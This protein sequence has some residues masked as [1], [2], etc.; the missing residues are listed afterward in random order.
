MKTGCRLLVVSMLMLLGSGAQALTAAPADISQPLG[1]TRDIGFRTS[2]GTWMS[3]D[4]SPDGRWIVFD[5]LGHIYRMPTSGGEAV[6]L[7]QASGVALNYHPRVSPDGRTIA[8]ISDRGGQENL[9]IM[10]AEGANPR[11]VALDSNARFAE[12]A[13]SPDGRSLLVTKRAKTSAGFYRTADSIWR[14]PVTGGSGA[15]LVA[16]GA[17]GGGAPA[18]TG[19][20]NGSGRAQWPS[21]TRDG[22]HVYFQTADFS[23]GGERRLMRLD[24]SGGHIVPVTESKAKA[25]QCCGVIAHPTHLVDVAPEVSPDG[26]YLAFARK[27]PEGKTSKDGQELNGRT[28][29]WLRDLETGEERLLMD[30]I[31]NTL[32]ELHAAWQTK[33]LPGY[34]W[35]P[36]GKSLILSQG[37]KIRRV[38]VAGG[39]VETIPFS[40]EVK[41]TISEQARGNFHLDDKFR[42]KAIRWPATSPESGVL[43]FEAA[44][45]LWIHKAPDAVV[46]PLTREMPDTFQLTPAWSPDGRWIAFA[47]SSDTE[48][49]HV[50]KVRP[51]GTGLVRLTRTAGRYLYPRWMAGGRR[52]SFSAWPAAIDYDPADSLYWQRASVSARGG[53]VRVDSDIPQPA[54]ISPDERGGYWSLVNGILGYAPGASA[55]AQPVVRVPGI[56]LPGLDTA[57]RIA[58]SPDGKRLALWYLNDIYLLDNPGRSQGELATLDPLSGK[59]LTFTGGYYPS[60]IDNDRLEFSEAAG[61]AIY[62]V[63]SGKVRRS[64]IQLDIPRSRTKGVIA[65]TNARILDGTGHAPFAGSIVVR[66]G[67]IACVGDCET[68]EAARVLSLE[69]RTVVP[70]FVDTHAHHLAVEGRDG[71]V[72][73]RRAASAAYL[74]NGV[75]T[76]FDPSADAD[77]HSFTVGEMIEAGAMIGPRTYSTGTALSCGAIAPVREIESFEEMQNQVDRLVNLGAPSIKD[78]KMC[79]RL[80][81]TWLAE[82]ARRRGVSLTSE[83]SDYHYMLGL[84]MTGHTGW[85]H[86]ILVKPTYS[87]FARFVGMAGGHYSGQLG[88]A[89]DYPD[90]AALEHWLARGNYWYNEK[91][92]RWHPWQ[93]M[94]PRRV[95]LS[96]PTSD[97][98]FPMQSLTAADIKAAGGYIATGGHGEM[99]GFD[100]HFEIWTL[101]QAMKPIDALA[102]ASMGGAHFLGLDKEIG[103]ITPGKVADL[104]VLNRDPLTEIEST[105]DIRYVM[106]DG[107]LHDAATLDVLWPAAQSYGPRNWTNPAISKTDTVPDN[108][109][110]R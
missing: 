98:G 19:V 52:V 46:M 108:V 38:Y 90:G 89:G 8:F 97:Y 93:Q 44:G 65:L 32:G 41:R 99:R 82:A 72:P 70:G 104:V 87:D 63:S 60:W 37:G 42:A 26:R 107:R 16:F 68:G 30:P 80:Q 110:D 69:G 62:S 54:D 105:T 34:A 67:R 1:K 4:V 100:T 2:E 51:D 36:D 47:T 28:A 88:I 20:W 58:V 55:G 50:W 71:L 103:S 14:F 35:M 74:A 48:G 22:R 106:K 6:S 79:T 77:L 31:S 24:L 102:A 9:W 64:S 101:A 94:A 3:L 75:T 5:L 13:W 109:W 78:Y 18:R 45:R 33:T 66:D 96:K 91:A 53:G 17:S 73:N 56:A 49:G 76:V 59:R 83:G 27:I 81:R 29:L 92:M 84:L 11:A 61:H 10:D 57:P 86:S 43:V 12:P 15:E 39:K 95:A 25:A 40:A 85:E 7:T 21:P 23:G